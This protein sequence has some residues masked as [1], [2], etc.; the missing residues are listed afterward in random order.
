MDQG[1]EAAIEGWYWV[2]GRQRYQRATPGSQKSGLTWNA[3]VV[4]D[5]WHGGWVATA[6]PPELRRRPIRFLFEGMRFD[7]PTAAMVAAEL[8]L[9]NQQV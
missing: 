4:L 2:A 5:T 6:E 9:S 3:Y 7:N 1:H 8:E